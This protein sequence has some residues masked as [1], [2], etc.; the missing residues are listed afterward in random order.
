MSTPEGM[1]LAE[2]FQTIYSEREALENRVETA[3]E[4]LIDLLQRGLEAADARLAE[5][6]REPEVGEHF[7][8][9][10][11]TGEEIL[12]ASQ[13]LDD[14]ELLLRA[15]GLDKEID[16]KRQELEKM[17]A[18]FTAIKDSPIMRAAKYYMNLV[19]VQ[20]VPIEDSAPPE[21]TGS[22]DEKHLSL[23]AAAKQMGLIVEDTTSK[24]AEIKESDRSKLQILVDPNNNISL[25]GIPISLS[26]ELKVAGK[27]GAEAA[28]RALRVDVLRYFNNFPNVERKARDIWEAI[29]QGEE[30]DQS[31]W[32]IYVKDFYRDEFTVENKPV[33]EVYRVRPRLLHYRLGNFDLDIQDTDKVIEFEREGVYTFPSGKEVGGETGQLLHL[34]ARANLETEPAKND[35]TPDDPEGSGPKVDRVGVDDLDAI[36][37]EAEKRAHDYTDP[38]L[39]DIEHRTPVDREAF[40]KL[41]EYYNLSSNQDRI[42]LP[43]L[44][45]NDLLD[46][47]TIQILIKQAVDNGLPRMHQVRGRIIN[48]HNG[49]SREH[50]EEELY[51]RGL[52]IQYGTLRKKA[53]HGKLGENFTNYRIYR[54]IRRSKLAIDHFQ[55]EEFDKG[56]V[57]WQITEDQKAILEKDPEERPEYVQKPDEEIRQ[58]REANTKSANNPKGESESSDTLSFLSEKGKWSR[59]LRA[60]TDQAILNAKNL[61]FLWGIT[62]GLQETKMSLKGH[63]FS[64][65]GNG[66]ISAAELIEVFHATGLAKGRME[67]PRIRD[68]VM[69]QLIHIHPFDK[70]LTHENP[71][72][73][74]RAVKVVE[75]EISLYFR[76]EAKG[77]SSGP[78]S[79][80]RR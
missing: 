55:P 80:R 53:Y 25:N 38:S 67:R 16:A 52:T 27:T 59:E 79:R 43:D 33:I 18:E 62:N 36:G 32:N 49:L 29:R 15:V 13:E 77:S 46:E 4:L 48:F 69:A 26:R 65:N 20:T 76:N 71:R 57:T 75:D 41:V 56:Q 10:R 2:E 22:D 63:K 58:L 9:L 31:M 47:G 51:L 35:D 78:A 34:L 40:P 45:V 68:I 50:L 66:E 8:R 19:E 6:S 44:M 5:L 24:T 21:T 61:G 74:E 72:V 3:P 30:F 28:G 7:S 17:Q 39:A 64:A 73:R 23:E 60:L 42:L 1:T 54:V 11:K 12:K 70:I 37:D 14:V